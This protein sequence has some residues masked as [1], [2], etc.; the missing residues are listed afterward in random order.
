MTTVSEERAG[1]INGVEGRFFACTIGGRNYKSGTFT[2]QK[3]S[4]SREYREGS[5]KLRMRV[6]IRFDDDCRNGHN[7]FSITCD[8]DAARGGIWTEWGGGA[9]HDDIARVFPEIAP[10]IKWHLVSSDGPMHYVANT[11]YHASNRDHNGLKAGETRQ[12]INGK[13]QL[14][15]WQIVAL[16][17]DGNEIAF[18]DLEKHPDAETKPVCPY[19][20]EYRPWCRVGEGKERDFKAARSTAVWPEAT[21]E[22][23]SLEPAELSAMLKDRLPSLLASFRADVEAAGFSWE[24]DPSAIAG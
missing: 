21:D 9:A 20:L 3:W 11:V 2:N 6:K 13:T 12:I 1:S 24:P 15:A 22:I 16:D 5:Q 14:P 7:T 8:I 4:S 18:H 17:A 23:L 19:T 10:L